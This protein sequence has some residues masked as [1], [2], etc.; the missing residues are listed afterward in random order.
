MT[1][2]GTPAP[3]GAPTRSEHMWQPNP[4]MNM[5]LRKTPE[6]GVALNVCSIEHCRLCHTETHYVH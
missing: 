6:E 3:L 2:R 4:R 5:N 1:N